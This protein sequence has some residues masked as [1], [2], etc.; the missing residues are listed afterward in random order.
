VLFFGDLLEAEVATVGLNPSDQE[1]LSKGGL[2]LAGSAQRFATLTSVGATDRA[3][4]TEAQC[5][6]AIAWMRDY[7]APGKPVYGWFNEMHGRNHL[8]SSTA[9][10]N[11]LIELQYRRHRK[12]SGPVRKEAPT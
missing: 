9:L 7:Y 3:S 2:M 6:E 11:G 1:Y 5:E 12:P 8:I 10:S 4:L